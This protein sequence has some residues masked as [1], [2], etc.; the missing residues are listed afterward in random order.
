MCSGSFGWASM[1]FTSIDMLLKLRSTVVAPLVT[2]A[3]P[4]GVHVPATVTVDVESLAMIAGLLRLIDAK[5][6]LVW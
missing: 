5:A 1:P 2:K 3:S 4:A 6:A